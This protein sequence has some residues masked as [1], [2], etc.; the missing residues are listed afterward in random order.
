MCGDFFQ[1]FHLAQNRLAVSLAD[2]TGHAM[3][4]AVPVMMFSGVLRDEL[5]YG[6]SLEKLYSNLTRI[7]YDM[8][9]LRTFVCFSMGEVEIPPA[10]SNGDPPVA[11]PFRLANGGVPIPFTTG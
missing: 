4:A 9:D 1:Y 8:L 10:R 2:V 3:E 5:Q 6:H 7:L 11:L